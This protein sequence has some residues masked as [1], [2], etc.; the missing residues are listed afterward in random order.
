MV[1]KHEIIEYGNEMPIKISIQNIEDMSR[2]WHSSLEIYLVLSGSLTVMFEDDT[3]KLSE[4]DIILINSNQFHEIKSSNTVAA[5][6][7]IKQ[8][9]FQQWVDDNT[10]FECN[11]VLY[12]DR[13]KYLELKK[14]IARLVHA[15]YNV[16][17]HKS[18]LIIPLSYNILYELIYN[19]RIFKEDTSGKNSKN[20]KR[21]KGI[22]QYLNDNYAENITLETIAKREYL[23]ASYLSHFFEKNMGISLFNYL[24][25]IR[26]RHAVADLLHT[27]LTIEQI[28]ANNGFS[29]S[30]Y[31]V[32]TFKKE[33]GT[34]PKQYKKEQKLLNVS[35]NGT[36]SLQPMLVLK[37][38]DFLNKL[39][40]YLDKNSKNELPEA[41]YP[42]RLIVQSINTTMKKQLLHHSFKTFT[43]VG[44]AKELLYKNVRE[45]LQELQREVR[46]QYIKFHGILDDSMM[47]Y[48]E[49]RNGNPYLVYTYVDDVLDFL[50]SIGLKPLI[51]F[52]FMPKLLSEDSDKTLFYNPVIISKPKDYKK[53][54]YLI[55]ELTKHLLKRYGSGE[56]RTWM[57]SFWNVP[58]LSYIFSFE[59]NE[60]TYELYR[61]TRNCV[62]ECDPLLSF[63]NPSYGSLDF[64]NSEFYDFLDYCKLHDCYP[65]F[66]NIHCYP[67]KTSSIGS[68]PPLGK[69]QSEDSEKDTIILSDDPDYMAHSIE[70]FKNRIQ[71]YPNLPIYITEWASTSSH[72]DWLNDTCYRSAYIVKNIL[73]NYDEVESFGNWCLTDIL[74]ELPMDNEE[75]H[76]ELGL[77]TCHGIKKPAYYAFTFLNKLMDILVDKGEGY[78]I[79]T[80]GQSD[81]AIL[82]YNYHHVSPLYAQGI[83]FNVTF[84]ERYNAFVNPSSLDIHLTL[85]HVENADYIV[86]HHVVNRESGSAFDEWVR[87]GAV[88][89][90][91]EEEINTLKGRSMPR[92]TK[93]QITVTNNTMAQ[94]ALLHPHEIR[95]I[96]IKKAEYSPSCYRP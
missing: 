87:M 62:K 7:Q 74:E 85:T 23:S 5:V 70:D 78:F 25:G 51:Q 26:L 34:L 46:F 94:F 69:N 19:F 86:T 14:L 13:N 45:H 39:G 63:G 50:L 49:D 10:Y 53:W 68:F 59:T 75:F 95:L 65:D 93:E 28:A 81:Y 55:T 31:F 77:F 60:I 67:V 41:K 20:L 76:G 48:N 38:Q 88:P 47:L 91:N 72:C 90:T 22:I 84:N 37:Q 24:A 2:H 27:D 96:Q 17:E 36:K 61:I 30:R 8:S 80:N 21:L 79:T 15:S 3:F 35:E 32:S 6:L 82:L 43:S 56:V 52:S 18:L 71:Y 4:D 1:S 33:Y 73:D 83:L 64:C 9:F 40:E 12:H 42:T 29:N 44:R 16:T 89:L 57:F 11:S 92:I 54:V 58:F 66:Y